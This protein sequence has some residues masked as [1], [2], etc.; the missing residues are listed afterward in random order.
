M[1]QLKTEYE[2]L[3]GKTVVTQVSLDNV[4]LFTQAARQVHLATMDSFGQNLRQDLVTLHGEEEADRL[5]SDHYRPN[6]GSA[7]YDRLVQQG[8]HPDKAPDDK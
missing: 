2:A 4:D 5:V 3:P 7:A 1:E 8:L 6:K